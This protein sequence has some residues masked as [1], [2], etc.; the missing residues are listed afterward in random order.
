MFIKTVV[1]QGEKIIRQDK[2]IKKL[3]LRY[4]EVSDENK[5]VYEENKELRCENEELEASIRTNNKLTQT[6]INYLYELQDVTRMGIVEK[7]KE[8]HRNMIINKIIKELSDDGK[9]K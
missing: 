3:K 1:R 7:D 5:A 8:K 9:S 2:E 4:K 6:V